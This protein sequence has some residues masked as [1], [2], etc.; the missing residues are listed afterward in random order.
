MN[1]DIVL[2][3]A[4]RDIGYR[5][6]KNKD[7]KYGRWFGVNHA[8]W[9]MMAV[10]YWYSMAGFPLPYSTASCGTLLRWYKKHQPECV[11][12]E[13]IP[14]CIVIFDFPKTSSETDHTGLFVDVVGNQII[15]V[16]G[17]PSPQNESS[18]GC[19]AKRVRFI[20][21]CKPVYI[22]PRGLEETVNIDELIDHMSDAQLLRLDALLQDAKS[23]Q[24]LPS[25]WNSKEMWNTAKDAGITDGNRPMANATRLEV[26]GMIAKALKLFK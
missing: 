20:K 8:N 4:E 2:A 24:P 6:G 18:G 23:K 3:Q 7:T 15:T 17:N 26:A 12:N 10:M 14:G 22:V 19:V 25:S 5:E 16:D 13:P 21:D 1:G 11:T 9:C